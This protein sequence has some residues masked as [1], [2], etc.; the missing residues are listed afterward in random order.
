MA[1]A[2]RLAASLW[3]KQSRAFFVG[4]SSVTGTA[5]PY[6]DIDIAHV[7]AE[8]YTGPLRTFYY[9][10]GL[11]AAVVVRPLSV[12]REAATQPERAIFVVPVVRSAIPLIDP[13]GVIA[14]FK[15]ELASFTW[16]PLQEKAKLSAGMLVASQAETVHKVLSGLA[17]GD[18]A[19]DATTMLTLEMTLAIAVF[20]GVLVEGSAAYMAQV[21]QSMGDTSAWS[22]WHRIATGNQER[23]VYLRDQ[24]IAALN[25]YRETLRALKIHM[26]PD[27]LELASA[28]DAVVES[29]LRVVS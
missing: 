21:R 2:D 20:R 19:Y 15:A 12:W 8:G 17:R 16:E 14:A 1:Y 28:T 22:R 26:A 23:P 10:G 4:G 9:D 29:V 5:T 6:S 7:V 25:L 3:S 11:L 24:A 18:N 13:E 27:R